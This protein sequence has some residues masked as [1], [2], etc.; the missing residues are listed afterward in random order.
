MRISYEQINIQ[1]M[2]LILSYSDS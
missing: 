2:P 1:F